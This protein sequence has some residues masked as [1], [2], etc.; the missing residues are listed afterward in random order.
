MPESAED[1]Y[2]RLVAAAD[3]QGRLPSLPGD[4]VS[5]WDIFPYETDSLVLRPLLPLQDAEPPRHGEAPATCWCAERERVDEAIAG[6]LW[7]DRRWMIV[8]ERHTP[9]LPAWLVL[10]PIEHLD[11]TDLTA[12]LAGELGV[13]VVAMAAAVESL[14]S[15]GRAHVNRW[16][17]GG[18]HLHVQVLGRPA[19]VGQLRGSCLPDWTEHLPPLPP[20][21]LA[22]NLEHVGAALRDR[23]ALDVP[24]GGRATGGSRADRL[25]QTPRAPKDTP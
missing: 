17:D 18:A 4:A 9:V 1:F 8:P 6:A 19:R 7:H 21:V 22:D 16:G 12:D 2:A 15:V 11:L 13:L 24:L 23:I 3:P 20:H 5:G 25:G 14:P 10:Q